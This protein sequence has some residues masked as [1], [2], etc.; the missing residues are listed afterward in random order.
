MKICKKNQKD[1]VMK[2]FGQFSRVTARLILVIAFSTDTNP[3]QNQKIG[4]TDVFQLE[5]VTENIRNIGTS[6]CWGIF[7]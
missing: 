3:D 1:R 4:V 6:L 5:G 2:I 7:R